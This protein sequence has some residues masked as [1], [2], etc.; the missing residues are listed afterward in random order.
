MIYH[1]QFDGVER[2]RDA[3]LNSVIGLQFGFV[4]RSA[5]LR[6]GIVG[7][8][9]YIRQGRCIPLVLHR[10]C[11]SEESLQIAPGIG[12][13]Y[14]VKADGLLHLR[15]QSV[16]SLLL[17][18]LQI[19]LMFHEKPVLPDHRVKVLDRGNILHQRGPGCRKRGELLRKSAARRRRRDVGSVGAHLQRREAVQIH[20]DQLEFLRK[21]DALSEDRY[22]ISAEVLCELS[23]LRDER[24]QFCLICGEL[25]III[26]LVEPFQRPFIIHFHISLL[27][28]ILR[29][30]CRYPAVSYARTSS[31]T[32]MRRAVR[33]TT[34]L[35]PDL[36]R[37][38]QL[39]CREL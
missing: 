4:C 22:R 18:V 36:P 16:H 24:I 7:F 29:P 27:S 26:S 13:G 12:S 39:P 15:R 35:L 31:P 19:E 30:C 10:Y 3:V 8:V 5:D 23:H 32:A 33:G 28:I 1:L 2:I 11:G 6:V 9:A 25:G 17:Y 14:L 20:C 21:P 34:R 38:R 37:G